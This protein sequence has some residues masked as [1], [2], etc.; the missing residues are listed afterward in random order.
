MS[1]HRIIKYKEKSAYFTISGA[2]LLLNLNS[3]LNKII[4]KI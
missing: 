4:Y 3:F 2:W 1:D